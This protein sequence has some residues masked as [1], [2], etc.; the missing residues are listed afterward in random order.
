MAA[1]TGQYISQSYGGVINFSTNTGIVTG[2]FTQLQ[3]GLG[4]NLG[5]FLNGQGA[6]SASSF[7]GS[8]F[9]TA[10]FAN[11][12]T[13]ASYALTATS[14]S[15]ATN[16]DLLDGLNSTVFTLTSSFIAFTASINAF[17]ASVLSYTASQNTLNGT[18]TTTASFNAY[19]GSTNA[20]SSSIL[21]QTASFNAFSASVLS[22]TS[23]LNA[24]TSSFATTGSN[25]FNGNQTITGSLTVTNG[26]IVTGS[27]SLTGS[28][29]ITGSSFNKPISVSIASS[30]ASLNFDS[31]NMFTLTL[32]NSAINTHISASNL[33]PGASAALQIT[34]GLAGS[35][36][37]TFN[38]TF[39]FPSGSS[40]TAF[41]SQS[42]NDV[43]SLLSFDGST[44]RA[45]GANNFI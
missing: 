44:L 41:T 20:F 28:L 15:Y 14:A 7:T 6:V 26:L 8:L 33:K 40:Y 35:A 36:T 17:S 3:D 37:V 42:A 22:Y 32:P 10:S 45:V 4:T 9:G 39:T 12:S 30:T 23:S 34:Q 31:S 19:T 24:K 2:S 18:F 1:L 11:N 27:Q 43:I 21:A 5:V 16:A 29:S 25:S 38:S 13:S